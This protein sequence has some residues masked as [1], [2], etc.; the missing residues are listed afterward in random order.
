MVVFRADLALG[1]ARGLGDDDVG[2]EGLAAGAGRTAALEVEPPRRSDAQV[3]EPSTRRHACY[4]RTAVRRDSAA[5]RTPGGRWRRRPGPRRAGRPGARRS[6]RRQDATAPAPRGVSR[7]YPVSEP[8]SW[9][10]S[11]A[12]SSLL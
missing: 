8:P 3:E 5:G 10:R 6:A 2:E 1:G 4:I 9:P 12:N 7:R 11:W